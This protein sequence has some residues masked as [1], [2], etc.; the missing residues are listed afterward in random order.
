MSTI[1]VDLLIKVPKLFARKYNS[2]ASNYVTKSTKAWR[3]TVLNL[4][5]GVVSIK[6]DNNLTNK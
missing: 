2:F 3:S 4:H 1:A 5:L 6:Y